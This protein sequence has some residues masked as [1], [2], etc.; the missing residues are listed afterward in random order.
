MGFLQQ[1]DVFCAPLVAPI[2][3]SQQR[4]FRSF[5]GRHGSVVIAGEADGKVFSRA[6]LTVA[7]RGAARTSLHTEPFALTPDG[8]MEFVVTNADLIEY[9]I[10]ISQTCDICGV[11]HAPKPLAMILKAKSIRHVCRTERL[12]F[13]GEDHPLTIDDYL[14]ANDGFEPLRDADEATYRD[15]LRE[16]LTAWMPPTNDAKENRGRIKTFL[17]GMQKQSGPTYCLEHDHQRAIPPLYID[18]LTA[19]TVTTFQLESMK[20]KRIATLSNVYRH[21]FAKAFADHISRVALPVPMQ[22]AVI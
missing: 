11:D 8:Q 14:T 17:G 2:T 9:F 19:F 5:D 21:H 6:E 10:V 1:G 18:F 20:D 7:L 15:R 13:K 4:I 22:K 3:D 16:T 12:P